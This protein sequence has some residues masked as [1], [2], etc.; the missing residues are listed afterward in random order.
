MTNSPIVIEKLAFSPKKAINDWWGYTSG[1]NK[2]KAIKASE[3]AAMKGLRVDTYKNVSD[4]S[5]AVNISVSHDKAVRAF[6]TL[7]KDKTPQLSVLQEK[8]ERAQDALRRE[9]EKSQI[10]RNQQRTRVAQR[11]YD[12]AVKTYEQGKLRKDRIGKLMNGR[13]NKYQESVLK[14]DAH[15]SRR[16]EYKDA[17]LR[18]RADQ[19]IA[20]RKNL[21][22]E[23]D[24]TKTYQRATA[25]T[26]GVLGVGGTGVAVARN[27]KQKE[28]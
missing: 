8:V 22:K 13:E 5:L 9:S 17:L 24:K 12:D 20:A 4:P 10:P 7:K 11:Q 16:Q 18:G 2:S 21:L 3:T 15:K 6:D 25:G 1:A 26:V 28:D 19:Q 23:T 27:R 14:L